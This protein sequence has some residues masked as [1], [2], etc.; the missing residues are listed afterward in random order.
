MSEN[1]AFY[2][3]QRQINQLLSLQC[4]VP[5]THGPSVIAESLVSSVYS[6]LLGAVEQML[7]KN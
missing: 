7:N 4:H 6:K 5:L 1:G 2:V 3:V